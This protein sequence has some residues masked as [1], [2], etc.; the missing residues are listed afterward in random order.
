MRGIALVIAVLLILVCQARALEVGDDCVDFALPTLL[1]DDELRLSVHRGK[2]VYLDFWASWCQ[3]CKES[4]TWMNRIQREY[5]AQGFQVIAVNLDSVRERAI[6]SL[7]SRDIA[8][9]LAFDP[10]GQVPLSYG[11]SAMPSS[12]LLDR[13]CKVVAIKRGFDTNSVRDMESHIQDLLSK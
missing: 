10:D 4:L 9:K 2:V 7:A 6:N 1:Q 5:A 11:V 12:Y 8:Y 13:Q 3:P